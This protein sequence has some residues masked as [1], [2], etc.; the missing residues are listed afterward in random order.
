MAAKKFLNFDI[1]SYG[2]IYEDALTV[3]ESIQTRKPIAIQYPRT[4]VGT[5]LKDVIHRFYG[6]TL[7][8]TTEPVAILN[9]FSMLLENI[10]AKETV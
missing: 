10:R 2:F 6:L 4:K 7:R 1:E 3:K 5:T 8:K 9:R